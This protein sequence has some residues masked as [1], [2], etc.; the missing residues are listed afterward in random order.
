[1]PDTNQGYLIMKRIKVNGL[2]TRYLFNPSAKIYRNGEKI[3]I[4]GYESSTYIDVEDETNL[5]F[6]V[7]FN[8]TSLAFDSNNVTEIFLF[9]DRFSGSLK[10]YPATCETVNSIRELIGSRQAAA[11][12]KTYLLLFALILFPVLLALLAA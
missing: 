10:A 9:L 8:K 5:T 3:G 11:N 6:K 12:L 2:T 1:M 4:V 7:M